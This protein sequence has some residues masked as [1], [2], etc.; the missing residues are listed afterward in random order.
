LAFW[1]LEKSWE[2]ESPFGENELLTVCFTEPVKD[3]KFLEIS[4]PFMNE[5]K[6]YES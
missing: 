1:R 6:L 3:L 2:G 4:F 5:E